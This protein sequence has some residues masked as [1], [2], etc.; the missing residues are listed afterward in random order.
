MSTF[1][2][3]DYLRTPDSVTAEETE[4]L[5][6][7]KALNGA[8]VNASGVLT[9]ALAW[10]LATI[11]IFN[12]V[13][14]WALAGGGPVANTVSVPPMELGEF[15]KKGAQGQ[16]EYYYHLQFDSR[17][18]RGERK[19]FEAAGLLKSFSHG[20]ENGLASLLAEMHLDGNKFM[21]Y[22]M[23]SPMIQQ[24]VKNRMDYVFADVPRTPRPVEDPFA[25]PIGLSPA[26]ASDG[27]TSTNS[28][29]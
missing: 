12:G 10:A 15:L 29:Q 13:K 26:Q 16:E 6:Q 19:M 27:D 23:E 9:T 1:N 3:A 2:I 5:A 11:P 20:W 22:V 25:P 28:G 7:Y 24:S 18:G 4:F 14:V 17:D 21:D 8:G